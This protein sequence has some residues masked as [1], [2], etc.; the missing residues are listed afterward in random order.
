MATRRHVLQCGLGLGALGATGAASSQDLQ[1]RQRAMLGFGTT[2]WLQAAHSDAAR[3]EAA[4][5]AS[6]RAI[7]RIEHE[8]SLFNEDS[9]LCR[10]NRQGHLHAA[11]PHLRQVL[12]TAQHIARA[13]AGA[14]DVSMQPLWTLWAQAAQHGGAPSA[15]A[16]ARGLQRVNWRAIE[17]RGHDILLN[18]A[19]MALSLNG[20][21]QGH[22]ADVVRDTLRRHDVRHALIDTGEVL[23]VGQAQ[24]A[25][26][27]TWRIASARP[28]APQG[29]RL[30][31]SGWAMATS[32]GATTPFSDDHRDHHIIDPRVGRS[33]QHWASVTVLAPSA[34]WA[35]ALTKVAFMTPAQHLRAM[36][37]AWGVAVVAQDLA[38]RW[39]R[40]GV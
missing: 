35:D 22:A 16:L 3:C 33:P 2:L 7:R 30:A 18:Q 12:R 39:H 11:P 26:P 24:G 13:S 1:W 8:L 23:P 36:S 14:L 28:D 19:G 29:P 17:Q 4:L 15:Q 40:H 32:S 27:W 6:V 20:L 37:K 9:A 5:D 21:G 10:L 25:T 34:T 31:P 38:G